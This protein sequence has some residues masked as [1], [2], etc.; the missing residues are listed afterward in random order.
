MKRKKENN[1]RIERKEKKR[2]EKEIG[3]YTAVVV[4]WRYVIDRTRSGEMDFA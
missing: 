1:E 3:S 2:K 4:L